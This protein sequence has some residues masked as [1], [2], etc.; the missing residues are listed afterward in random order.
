V[1]ALIRHLVRSR[2]EVAIMA[3]PKE[4]EMFET[5]KCAIRTELEITGLQQLIEQKE[6][7]GVDTEKYVEMLKKRIIDK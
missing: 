4:P 7:L 5:R 6:L 3:S 1:L 2:G